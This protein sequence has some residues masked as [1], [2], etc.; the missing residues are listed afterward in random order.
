MLWVWYTSENVRNAD[1]QLQA[2]DSGIH[3]IWT[4]LP[5]A[6]AVLGMGV[7]MVLGCSQSTSHTPLR[8][9][10]ACPA[11]TL[12]IWLC[13][14]TTVSRQWREHSSLWRVATCAC[15][16]TR[17]CKRGSEGGRG[18]VERGRGKRFER[19]WAGRV[20]SC[21]ECIGGGKWRRIGVGEVV[22]WARHWLC[23]R[24]ICQHEHR[25]AMWWLPR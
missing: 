12:E 25:V 22:K 15:S 17:M 14:Q 2:N 19:G 21:V 3:M 4:N 7:V 6:I 10:S 5:C 13:S 8:S 9:K 1:E 24:W 11:L 20:G 16:G 23:R 18:W